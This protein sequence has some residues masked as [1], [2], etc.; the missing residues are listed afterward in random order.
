[1]PA[2]TEWVRVAREAGS[3]WREIGGFGAIG[4][5]HPG[6]ARV[7]A[8]GGSPGARRT[9]LSR[10]G[11]RN[12]ESLL[13]VKALSYRYDMVSTG[14]PVANYVAE[15]GVEDIGDGTSKVR[16]RAEFT[17]R[18]ENGP[19]AVAGIRAFLRAWLDGLA[20]RYGRAPAARLI[21]INHVAL[22]VGDLDAALAFYGKLFDF[23]LRGRSGRMAFIDMGDQFIAL[24]EGR[25]QG[26]DEGRHFGLVVDDRSG[27][28]E[29]AEAAGA[30]FTT[31][32]GLEIL[33]PWGNHIEV[34]E[35]RR[36]QFT[37]ADAV[38]E[39]LHVEPEK[40]KEAVAEL[41][42]KGIV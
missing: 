24:S 18:G 3:L 38:L 34:V 40:T 36:I 30:T 20:E 32:P 23:E 15:F 29:R 14:L 41:L 5:W 2:I 4:D 27:V 12:V 35:Y 39:A 8:E 33:D 6:L 13:E 37:K 19:A 28:R 11:M 25:R 42:N 21:G 16:W 9:A 10:E 7:E 31:G 1:M 26:P 22:E 17:T